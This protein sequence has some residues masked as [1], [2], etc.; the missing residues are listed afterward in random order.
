VHTIKFQYVET[1]R[2]KCPL[3][4]GMV[5]DYHAPKNSDFPRTIDAEPTLPA[6]VHAP[7]QQTRST[8]VSRSLSTPL[9]EKD[10]LEKDSRP[11]APASHGVG[12]VVWSGGTPS[13]YPLDR[14][15]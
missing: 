10:F 9:I 11:N 1:L 6:R 7:A 4:R 3:C 13:S 5:D 2:G 12:S 15:K 8:A 14:C